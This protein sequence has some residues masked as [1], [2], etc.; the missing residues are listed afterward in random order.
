MIKFSNSPEQVQKICDTSRIDWHEKNTIPP[1]SHGTRGIDGRYWS[2]LD[3]EGTEM[4]NKS[5]THSNCRQ[6]QL[7]VVESATPH[8]VSKRLRSLRSKRRSKDIEL[9]SCEKRNIKKHKF[10]IKIK[11]LK[12][13]MM[14]TIKN[15][16][17]WSSETKTGDVEVMDPRQEVGSSGGSQR[18]SIAYKESSGMKTEEQEQEIYT[19]NDLETSVK[20]VNR[21]THKKSKR[22][23]LGIEVERTES[24]S[25]I[26]GVT[27]DLSKESSEMKTED[28]KVKNPRQEVGNN[29][30]SRSITKEI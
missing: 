7:K 4:W 29:G 16:I 20:G 24:E 22:Y 18:N 12:I 2:I 1:T 13:K 25:T 21:K 28:E 11:L 26:Y 19:S 15:I 10:M 30:R 23:I 6:S 27:K 14:E 17:S 3:R 9:K 8:R 5:D